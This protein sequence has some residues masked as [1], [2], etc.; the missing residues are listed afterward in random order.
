MIF[1]AESFMLRLKES[2]VKI[3]LTLSGPIFTYG[4]YY[5]DIF[6]DFF[7]MISLFNN[8]HKYYGI[9]SLSIIC[10]S[11][12]TTAAFVTFKFHTKFTKSLCYPL[13]HSKNLLHQLKDSVMSIWDGKSFPDELEESKVFGHH[14][15]FLE[16]MSESI[17][18]LCLQLIVLREFGISKE[19]FQSF[20]QSSC[21]FSSLISICLLFSK[22]S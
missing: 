21:L 9:I 13:Q 1:I 10:L 2:P 8:C 17:P 19:P 16:A 22:V 20:T 3:V 18:Q 6:S 7:H 14:I 12:A 11:Y 15:A 4:L 5:F